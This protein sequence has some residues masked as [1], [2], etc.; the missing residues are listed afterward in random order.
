M[1]R[2]PELNDVNAD[3]NFTDDEDK[4]NEDDDD[5]DDEKYE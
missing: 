1:A 5:D 3:I 2:H 4:D